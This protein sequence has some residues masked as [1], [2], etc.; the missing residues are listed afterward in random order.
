MAERNDEVTQ[1]A[2]TCQT[3][4]RFSAYAIANASKKLERI[5]TFSEAEPMPNDVRGKYTKL[6]LC[7]HLLEHLLWQMKQK[8]TFFLSLSL[9]L[10][11][12]SRFIR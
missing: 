2:Q 3:Y 4:R 12:S 7:E 5:I 6:D 10:Y 11:L 8:E 9:A 1:R